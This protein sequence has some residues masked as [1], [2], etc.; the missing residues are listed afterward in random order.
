MCGIHTPAFRPA[1]WCLNPHLQTLWPYFFRRRSRISYR[2]ERVELDDGDFLDLDWAGDPRRSVS[3]VL[4]LH[5]LEGSSDSPA[6]RGMTGALVSGGHCVVVMHFRGCSGEP[7]RLARAYHSG[8]TGDVAD[9]VERLRGRYPEMPVAV[10][11]YSLGG[12]VLLKWLGQ[13]DDPKPVYA[14]AAVSVPFELETASRRL[15]RGLSRIYQ[16]FFLRDMRRSVA[17]RFRHRPAPIDL[18]DLH[19]WRSFVDFDDKVTAPLHGFRDWKDYYDRSSCRQYLGGVRVPTL[20]VHARDDPF[21]EPGV[22]P[23][24]NEVSAAVRM[25][26]T[27]RGGH[28]GFVEGAVPGH[29]RYWLDRRV[30]DHF[31]Q[32]LARH[33]RETT[34]R[35]P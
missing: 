20:L 14:A 33:R 32:H 25:T 24:T 6:I 1:W 18:T 21:M 9:I 8:D 34:N 22:I 5:G 2:R 16:Y 28:V 31:D 30:P 15:D 4:I 11:G 19:R 3:L 7:N 29:A 17:R 12:N 23:N 35:R 27:D 13:D 10:L 26:I